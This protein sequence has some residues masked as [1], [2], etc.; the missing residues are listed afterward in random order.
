MRNIAEG[1]HTELTMS[2]LYL[3]E[4]KSEKLFDPER[5]FQFDE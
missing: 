5:F 3:L 1:S 4:S 2:D